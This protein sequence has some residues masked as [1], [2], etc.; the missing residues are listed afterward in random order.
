MGQTLDLSS[1]A[2]NGL[3]LPAFQYFLI[4]NLKILNIILTMAFLTQVLSI[5][6]H[7]G[8]DCSITKV[9]TNNRNTL[10]KNVFLT[11]VL[12]ILQKKIST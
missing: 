12:D 6:M 7:V 5:L 3:K 9:V 8:M 4:M 1:L 2:V 11:H 10:C